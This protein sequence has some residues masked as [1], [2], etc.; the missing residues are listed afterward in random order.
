[1]KRTRMY[2]SLD[3]CMHQSVAAERGMAGGGTWRHLVRTTI[4]AEKPFA[5]RVRA[6]VNVGRLR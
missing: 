4:A 5:R 1:M 6:V 3:D 2:T